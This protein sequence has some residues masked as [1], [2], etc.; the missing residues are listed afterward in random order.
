MVLRTVT[1]LVRHRMAVS[2]RSTSATRCDTTSSAERVDTE[3]DKGAT[4]ALHLLRIGDRGRELPVVADDGGSFFDA[5][6]VTDD[7]DGDFFATGGIHRLRSA[8]SAGDLSRADISGSRI[9]APIETPMAVICIGQNYAAH[10]RE[11]GAVPPAEPVVFLKHPNCITG[12][13]DDLPIPSFAHRV[14]WEVEL[15]VVIGQRCRYLPS[16][17]AALDMVAG[18][19]VSNDV[20]ERE[21][22]LE[23]SGGQWSKGKCF[24]GFNPLGPYLYPADEVAA[25]ALELFSW[26][27]GEARQASSTADMIFGVAELVYELSQIMVLEPGDLI[28]TGTPQGVALSGAFPYLKTGDFLSVEISGLGRQE[29]Q[30]VGS[31]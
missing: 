29:Q 18:Y 10:A 22:Q 20:S 9:G 5:R 25:G 17:E 24:E 19:T 11:M 6:P 7:Y 8:L 14:D 21:F 23:R 27:N 28:N 13:N 3:S 2:I 1:A 31:S 16:R 30:V 12:P 15:G 26:V 4:S